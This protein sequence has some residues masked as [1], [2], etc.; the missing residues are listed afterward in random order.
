MNKSFTEAVKGLIKRR[1]EYR[2]KNYQLDMMYKNIISSISGN[3]SYKNSVIRDYRASV[4]LYLLGQLITLK[5][6]DELEMEPRTSVIFVNTDGFIIKTDDE[7]IDDKLVSIRK[8][9]KL[10]WKIKELDRLIIKDINNYLC[11]D[12]KGEITGVGMFNVAEA[13]IIKKALIDYFV[14]GVDVV[15][16]VNSA[17]KIAD[18]CLYETPRKPYV[19][20]YLLPGKKSIISNSCR[21]FVSTKVENIGYS[22]PGSSTVKPLKAGRSLSM[23]NILDD[24]NVRYVDRQYYMAQANAIINLKK[25]KQLNL[26]DY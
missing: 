16:T 14:H 11:I 10:E 26:W 21:Y 19:L 3:L 17:T 7:G 15:T 6:V 24:E 13:P 25:E 4:Q 5:I 20:W 18:F 23:A 2:D 8:R 12:A 9:F 22:A 1:N